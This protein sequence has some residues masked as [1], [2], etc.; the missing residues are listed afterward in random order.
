MERDEAFREYVDRSWPGLV[1][2]ARLLGSGSDA[3]DLT[4]SALL[5]AYLGWERVSRAGNVDAY[6]Y[7]ILVNTRI[8]SLRRRSS[9]EVLTAASPEVA[10]S[11]ASS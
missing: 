7:R 1:R 4:Q 3:E 6:V 2:T 5:K 10:T 9:G 11:D 8:S